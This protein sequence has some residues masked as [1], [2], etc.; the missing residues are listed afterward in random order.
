MSD[1]NTKIV[2]TSYILRAYQAEKP[3]IFQIVNLILKKLFICGLAAFYY[4]EH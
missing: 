4:F 2:P 1:K 3:I